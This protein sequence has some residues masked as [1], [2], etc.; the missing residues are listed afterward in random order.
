[1][2][3]SVNQLPDDFDDQVFYKKYANPFVAAI[4]PFIRRNHLQ[5][6]LART[7]FLLPKID[8]KRKVPSWEI[9]PQKRRYAP[10]TVNPSRQF[11][12]SAATRQRQFSLAVIFIKSHFGLKS[13]IFRIEN[14]AK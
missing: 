9:L 2:S 1:M 7:D 3:F 13:L 10:Q 11:R 14:D 8:R 6:P 12:T 5:V 4:G